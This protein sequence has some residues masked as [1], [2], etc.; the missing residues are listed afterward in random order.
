MSVY[1]RHDKWRAEVFINS[2]RVAR[3]GG[4]KKKSDA[5]RWKDQTIRKYFEDPD[6]FQRKE[7]RFGELLKKFEEIHLKYVKPSTRDRYL[8]E[9]NLRI[10]PFFQNMKLM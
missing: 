3:K 10:F 4:F 1:K 9:I 5:Q 8:L 7:F 2:K 6:S